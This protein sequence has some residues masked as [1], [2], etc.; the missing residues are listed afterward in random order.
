MLNAKDARTLSNSILKDR[1]ARNVVSL[2]T[3][4]EGALA[5]ATEAG[6][7]SA[8]VVVP[9]STDPHTLAGVVHSLKKAGYKVKTTLYEGTLAPGLYKQARTVLTLFW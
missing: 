1:E 4:L 7:V 3:T 5:K 9:P 6:L 8:S 2:R